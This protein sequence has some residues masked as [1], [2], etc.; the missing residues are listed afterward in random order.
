M[1]KRDPAMSLS[2]KFFRYSSDLGI[3]SLYPDLFAFTIILVVRI[4][5]LPFEKRKWSVL[6]DIFKFNILFDFY[7]RRE[8][9][10]CLGWWLI[11]ALTETRLLCNVFG[12]YGES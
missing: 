5:I 10:S 8:C 4:V 12:P 9:T 3:L 1:T 2:V 7:L 6:V 11:N